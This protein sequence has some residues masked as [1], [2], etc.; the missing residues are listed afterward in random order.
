MD[1]VSPEL[2]GEVLRLMI[3]D[4]V[5]LTGELNQCERAVALWERKVGAAAIEANLAGKKL[6]H[7]G[8][9]GNAARI[10]RKK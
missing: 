7:P 5:T 2:A 10:L 8:I 9:P 1:K 4:A 6:V 3:Q